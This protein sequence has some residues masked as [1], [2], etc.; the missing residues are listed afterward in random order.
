MLKLFSSL[1]SKISFTDIGTNESV[2]VEIIS[3][4]G[5][6]DGELIRATQSRSFC[7][8]G[9][10][11]GSF[12]KVKAYRRNRI[13]SRWYAIKSLCDILTRSTSGCGA[14]GSALPWGN[15]DRKFNSCPPAPTIKLYLSSAL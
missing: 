2:P 12:D 13:D 14:V 3:Q 8:A 11:A 9:C 7:Y 15:Y 6:P 1:P 10:N 4:L 5:G